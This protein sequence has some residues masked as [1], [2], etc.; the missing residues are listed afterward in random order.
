[1]TLD[2]G[3]CELCPDYTIVDQ[4]G[5]NCIDPTCEDHM[6]ILQD[7]SCEK[8]EDNTRVS[9]DLKSCIQPSCEPKLKLESDGTTC[10]VC[11]PD[12]ENCQQLECYD[13]AFI[14]KSENICH[15]FNLLKQQ[16]HEELVKKYRSLE[17]DFN[18]SQQEIESLRKELEAEKEYS[19]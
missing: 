1:M 2:D 14:V 8:C 13:K 5:K 19:K 17:I 11:P 9:T 10:G 6:I 18:Q 3:S 16:E 4:D 7:G 15:D 12:D